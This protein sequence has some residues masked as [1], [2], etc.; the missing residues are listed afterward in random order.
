M[1]NGV[2]VFVVSLCLFHDL[3]SLHVCVSLFFL[4]LLVSVPNVFLRQMKA[5]SSLHEMVE[6]ESESGNYYSQD[7]QPA[8]SA[9]KADSS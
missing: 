6:R 7:G 5:G 4:H 8:L 2:R 3:L 1:G 9:T